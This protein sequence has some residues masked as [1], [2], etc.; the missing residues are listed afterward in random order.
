MFENLHD[1]VESPRVEGSNR[2][3][4]RRDM[5]KA[6]CIASQFDVWKG[7]E[8]ISPD[9][10]IACFDASRVF[11]SNIESTWRES[12]ASLIRFQHPVRQGS[13]L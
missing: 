1:M 12:D 10:L 5:M 7:L 11:E 9:G 3:C 4:Y 13:T 2:F 8:A 6:K